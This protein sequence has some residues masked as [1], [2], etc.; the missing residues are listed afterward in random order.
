M[1]H[2]DIPSMHFCVDP[3]IS[4]CRFPPPPPPPPTRST[5]EA[6]TS[7]V[8]IVDPPRVDTVDRP[9]PTFRIFNI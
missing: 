1:M 9:P 5:K 4:D 6:I 8:L 2:H 3:P 7:T